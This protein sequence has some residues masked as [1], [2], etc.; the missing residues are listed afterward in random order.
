[1]TAESTFHEIK[2]ALSGRPGQPIVLGVCQALAVRFK[3][4]TWRVRG[5]T[6]IL[7]L[8]WPLPVLAAYLV[9]G[10][11]LPETE[12]RSR[13]FFSGLAIL[14]RET[15]EKVFA[16]LGGLFGSGPGTGTR[17]KSY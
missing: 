12:Q 16:A 14:V 2:Q 8:F 4:E 15:A 6:I 10:F 17:T 11:V 13:G 1:M 7:G 3:Q 9:L 5:V